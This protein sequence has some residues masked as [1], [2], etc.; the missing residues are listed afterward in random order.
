ML[1]TRGK[2]KT[3]SA[4]FSNEYGKKHRSTIISVNKNNNENNDIVLGDT[5]IKFREPA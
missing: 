5:S 3:I 4:A 2:E 1:G